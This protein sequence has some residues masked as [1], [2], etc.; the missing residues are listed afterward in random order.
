M[1]TRRL[2]LTFFAVLVPAVVG[3]A[4]TGTAAGGNGGRPL[5]TVLLGANEAPNAGDPDATGTAKLRLNSGRQRVCYEL[6]W[7]NVDGTVNAAHIHEAPPGEAGP[8]RVDL[9]VGQSLPGTGSASA[10]VPASRA[11]IKDIRKDPDDYYVN[12][13]SVPNFPGGAI[14]GQL[15]K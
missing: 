12:V 5:D 3:I 1:R 2:R 8:I 13:H 11:L 6:T 9:F 15:G 10:C 4:L 14:R 7:R